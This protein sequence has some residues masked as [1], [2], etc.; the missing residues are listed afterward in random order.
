MLQWPNPSKSK[1]LEPMETEMTFWP[2]IFASAA[3]SEKRHKAPVEENDD[4]EEK[5]G[6]RASEEGE[7]KVYLSFC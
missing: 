1:F 6:E 5:V 3:K 2:C 7:Q 4:E